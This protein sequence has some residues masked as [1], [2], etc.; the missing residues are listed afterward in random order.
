MTTWSLERKLAALQCGAHQ[1]AKQHVDEFVDMI[2]K[3]QWVLLPAHVVMADP[4]LRLNP[5]GVVSQLGRRPR[6]ICDYS[7]FC[8][9]DIIMRRNIFSFDDMDWLQEIGTA[10]G[11]L[12]ACSY[13]TI[14][15]VLHEVQATLTKFTEFLVLLK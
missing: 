3:G 5:L 7:F 14:S 8:V 10:M 1:S 12:C 11:I 15:Y 2:N 4:N 13:S 6:T 9:N